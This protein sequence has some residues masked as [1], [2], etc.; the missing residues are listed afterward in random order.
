MA[1][2]FK[3]M[4]CFFSPP[5]PAGRK[6]DSLP[7]VYTPKELHEKLSRLVGR[8]VF[9]DYQRHVDG[10]QTAVRLIGETFRQKGIELTETAAASQARVFIYRLDNLR[11]GF[12]I[13]RPE[14]L[15]PQYE[16]RCGPRELT[17][18]IMSGVCEFLFQ[19][20]GKSC[21]PAAGPMAAI[22]EALDSKE[23][24][25]RKTAQENLLTGGGEA[26]MSLIEAVHDLNRKITATLLSGNTA[27]AGKCMEQLARRLETLGLMRDIQALVP[28]LDA[29]ADAAESAITGFP[30]A[31]A[32]RDAASE[33]VCHLGP[34]AIPEI[35]R[36]LTWLEA[37]PQKGTMIRQVLLALSERLR[38]GKF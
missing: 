21:Q 10:P 24:K 19:L 9:L 3:K 1:E 26:T 32:L 16:A 15:G 4:R 23:G 11:F 31:A 33:A 25:N 8:R 17:M 5:P 14:G 30:P 6:D 28:I 2:F 12:S 37:H 29:L 36:R 27:E 13:S 34:L 20:D 7:L 22:I 35:D 38:R 18:A